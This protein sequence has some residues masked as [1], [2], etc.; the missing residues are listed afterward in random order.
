LRDF[1]DLEAKVAEA[2]YRRGNAIFVREFVPRK[3]LSHVT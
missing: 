3:D 1:G 2:S